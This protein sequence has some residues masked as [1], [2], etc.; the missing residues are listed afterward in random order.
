M[1]FV[2]AIRWPFTNVGFLVNGHQR[3]RFDSMYHHI[4]KLMY[5]VHIGT[6]D[7]RF[8]NILLE[9]FGRA[10]ANLRRACS[11]PFKA[12]DGPERKEL[13]WISAQRN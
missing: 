12:C 8:G 11:I 9:Q 10:K 5:T 2:S 6:P 4:K 13:L 1:R 3:A 7:P